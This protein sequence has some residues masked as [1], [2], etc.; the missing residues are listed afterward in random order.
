MMYVLPGECLI[1]SIF[2]FQVQPDREYRG[3]ITILRD[4]TWNQTGKAQVC[5]HTVI[6]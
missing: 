3:L 6:S 4:L 5:I 2:K 1:G